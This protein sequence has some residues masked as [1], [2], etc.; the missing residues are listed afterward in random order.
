MKALP[1]L[2][3]VDEH[4]ELVEVSEPKPEPGW[5]VLEV[6]YAGICGTDLHIAHNSFP[7]WLA[8]MVARACGAGR[9]VVVGRASSR[10]RLDLARQLGFDTW[11]AGQ[12]EV[13]AQALELTD[14]RGVDLVLECSGSAD[15][16]AA[17]IAALRRRGRLCVLGMSGRPTLAVPWDLAMQRALDISFSLSSSW[18]SWDG[19]LA[20][21][22][23]GAVDPTPL[24]SVFPLS[25][26][27]AAFEGIRERTAVKA[28]LDPRPG[29]RPAKRKGAA[30]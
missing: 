18:S 5:V 25:D 15:G 6:T 22:A 29:N 1:K 2:T 28:L 24:A 23:R 11:D 13:A 27:R 10:T 14:G 12:L 16:V 4:L 19:A 21:L 30:P 7:S 17:G 3:S 26:W 9:I 20:L 8:A